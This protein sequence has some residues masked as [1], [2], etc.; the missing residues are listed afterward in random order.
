MF[1]DEIKISHFNSDGRTWCWV[2][3]KEN[4]LVRVMNPIV[5]HGGGF[6]MLWGCLTCRG[7]RS[8]HNIQGYLN[9]RGYIPIL[10]Q[11]LCS[12][13]LAFGFNLEEIIFQQHNNVVHTIK[14]VREWFEKQPFCVIEWHA[15]SPDLNPNEHIW[16]LLKR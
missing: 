6:I 13:L 14:I 15:Q 11:V 12:I 1:S 9:A 4:I 3:D 5:K 8:L 7:L 10:E 2:E 16:A